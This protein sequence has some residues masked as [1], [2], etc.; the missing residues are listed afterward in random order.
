MTVE[1]TSHV[2][3]HDFERELDTWHDAGRIATFWWRDDDAV[4]STAELDQL[5]SIARAHETPIAL[6]VIPENADRAF[7]KAH[8]SSDACAILQHGFSHTNHAPSSEK[9]AEFG[10]HRPVERMVRDLEAGQAVMQQCPG[11]VAAF[12]PP[13][14]RMTDRLLPHLERLGFS[15][16]STFGPRHTK[17]PAPRL[18]QVNTHIDPIEWRGTRGFVGDTQALR[19]ALHHLRGRR[20]GEHDSDEPTGLLTHHLIHQETVWKFVARFVKTIAEH[21]ASRWLSASEVFNG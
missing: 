6:A 21:P 14:N 7:L 3:W 8:S 9:K 5:N 18:R 12:V 1:N 19:Q 16:F 17:N 4:R 2:G 13:W 20:T 15:G 10:G 11:F